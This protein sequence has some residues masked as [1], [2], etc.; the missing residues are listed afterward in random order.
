M[1]A[2]CHQKNAPGGH[3][4]AGLFRPPGPG[5]L[6]PPARPPRRSHPT[7][8]TPPFRPPEGRTGAP[9]APPPDRAFG[10]GSQRGKKPVRDGISSDEIACKA[11]P[12]A[13]KS[14]FLQKKN[15]SEPHFPI[16]MKV[17]DVFTF[18]S[19]KTGWTQVVRIP[20][21]DDAT[22]HDQQNAIKRTAASPGALQP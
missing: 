19:A 17:Q 4:F 13:K 21:T 7:G 9:F 16:A 18:R 12:R 14:R 6:R 20:G 8:R 1:E 5:F 3:F 11:L 15:R 22:K 10:G 2:T